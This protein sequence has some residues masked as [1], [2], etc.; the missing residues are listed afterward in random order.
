MGIDTWDYN[1]ADQNMRLFLTSNSTAVLFFYDTQHNL[2]EYK[3]T[4]ESL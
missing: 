1:N 4:L 3:F 2:S